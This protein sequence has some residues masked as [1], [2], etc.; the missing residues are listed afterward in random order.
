MPIRISPTTS[1][2]APQEVVLAIIPGQDD[3]QRMVF[4]NRLS[5]AEKPIVLRQESFSP[6]VGWFTQSSLEMTREEMVLLRAA[7]GG[8]TPAACMST[9]LKA[10]RTLQAPS[11]L[12]LSTMSEVS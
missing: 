3:S 11:I 4:A 8:T 2:S 9:R 5:P 7:M 10:S 1:S 12:P 6:D